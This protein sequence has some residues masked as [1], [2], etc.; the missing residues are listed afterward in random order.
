MEDPLHVAIEAL[1]RAIQSREVELEGMKRSLN[2]LTN[3]A[4]EY[5]GTVKTNEWAGMGIT[6]AAVLWLTEVGVPRSTPEIAE[7][8]RDRGV[9]TRSKNY[10]A[11]VYATLRNGLKWFV[12]EDGL[13]RLATPAEAKA[14]QAAK[15]K[16]GV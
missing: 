7:A 6:D 12:R 10:T 9:R 14:G 2:Q 8:I 13:W 3:N 11:T 5:I 4:P 16:A 15:K 1:Q